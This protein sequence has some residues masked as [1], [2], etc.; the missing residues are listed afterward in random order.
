MQAKLS[1]PAVAVSSSSIVW[2]IAMLLGGTEANWELSLEALLCQ[3]I[4]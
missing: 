2:A 1:T 3:T 4:I